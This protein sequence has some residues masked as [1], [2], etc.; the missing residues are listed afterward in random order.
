VQAGAF[1]TRERAE[2]FRDSLRDNFRDARIIEASSIWRVVVGRQLNI[3]DA[4]RLAEK[5]RKS[6]G[7]AVIIPDPTSHSPLP[8]TRF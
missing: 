4:T 6:T 1:S 2:T 3:D 7:Q 8:T 5:V